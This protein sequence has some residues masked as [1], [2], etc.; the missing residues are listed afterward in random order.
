LAHR[1][2][3]VGGT[4]EV[5][6]LPTQRK[7]KVWVGGRGVDGGEAEAGAVAGAVADEAAGGA[8][9]F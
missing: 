8:T 9:G 2:A 3:E 7:L 5:I 4:S 1:W 6:V